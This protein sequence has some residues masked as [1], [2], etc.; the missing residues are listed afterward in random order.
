MDTPLLRNLLHSASRLTRSHSLT[1]RSSGV[2]KDE[3]MLSIS[4]SE[5]RHAILKLGGSSSGSI[6]RPQ[7]M[8][9]GLCQDW[10]KK[11]IRAAYPKSCSLKFQN[12][13]CA[14][15]KS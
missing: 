7:L 8:G 5:L 11:N 2:I 6:H 15:C 3:K 14:G 12:S 4:S 1:S 9:E 13:G 10:E